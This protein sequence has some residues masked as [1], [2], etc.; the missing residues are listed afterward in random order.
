MF[1]DWLAREGGIF[2]SWWLLA[3]LAGVAVLP[4]CMRL[5]SGLPDRGYTFARSIGILLVAF[6]F[7]VLASLGFLQNNVGSIVVSWLIVLGIG[8]V[9]YAR[10]GEAIDLK[11]FWRENKRVIVISEILFV[12]LFFTW[13]V[14]RAFAND[15]ATTEKPMDLM[16]ISSIMR[17]DSFPP[18]DAWMSGYSISY[19]HFGYIMSAMLSKMSNV[20]STVGFS[21]TLALWFALAGTNAFG[22]VYNLVRSRAYHNETLQSDAPKRTTPILMGLLATIFIVLLSNLQFPLI[23]L[24]WQSGAGDASYYDYWGTQ[25]RTGTPPT[26]DE[27][28]VSSPETWDY[29]WWFRAS[30]VLNDVNLDGT[31]LPSWYAQPIDIR[32]CWHCRLG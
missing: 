19:Y 6:V 11:A 23:E 18:N 30:R 22:V 9:A 4:L 26:R 17:S 8:S 7:W 20:T 24:P 31:E 1:G 2:I 27:N 29:W 25:A 5:L 21:M 3:T 12:S 32:M 10:M 14:F 13:T 16:F 15:T 28:F